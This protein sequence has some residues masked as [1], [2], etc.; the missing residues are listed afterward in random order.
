VKHSADVVKQRRFDDAD[1][2]QFLAD[3]DQ[4]M[5]HNGC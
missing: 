3:L 2:A 1:C 5:I 4:A